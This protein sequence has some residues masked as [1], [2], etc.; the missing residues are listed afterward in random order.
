MKLNPCVSAA[1]LRFH[2]ADNTIKKSLFD[3]TANEPK[4]NYFEGD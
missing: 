2:S 1:V 4:N 3:F